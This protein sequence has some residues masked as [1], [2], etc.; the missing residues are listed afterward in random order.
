[1]GTSSSYGGPGGGGGLLPSYVDDPDDF[2]IQPPVKPADSQPP[3]S[4]NPDDQT[5]PAVDPQTDP[6]E[7]P[8]KPWAAPK[9]NLT[10]YASSV[11]AGQPKSQY[12]TN[13]AKGFVRAQ[14]GAGR[15]SRAARAGR[16]SAVNLGGFL[17]YLSSQGATR[18]VEH[19]G[20]RRYV[21]QSADT[22]LA[23]LCDA[24]APS[25]E[26]LEDAVARSAM[27]ETL[28]DTFDQFA[29]QE[30][31]FEVL[32]KLDNPAIGEI[33]ERYIA[34][35]VY[36]RLIEVLAMNLEMSKQTKDVISTEQ[37]IRDFVF[38]NV[39][40]EGLSGVDF[41]NI[42]WGGSEGAQ[43]IDRLFRQA[44]DLFENEE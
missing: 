24:I 42:D 44:F 11:S 1:M 33:V 36:Y 9:S 23:G 5:E 12:A 7:L 15:A 21:G 43:L 19:Y 18:T 30:N 16:R 31:G 3:G 41:S 2:G 39:R 37:N 25:G 17:G 14:G 6:S 28:A 10:R 8:E 32:E 40:L 27:I 29:V 13:A 20:L 22:L 4:D 26:T 34:Y 38:A 35:Y